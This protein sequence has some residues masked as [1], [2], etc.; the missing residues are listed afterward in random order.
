MT[1]TWLKNSKASGYVVRYIKNGKT[2]TKTYKGKTKTKATLSLKKG[3]YKF[4]VRCY[5]NKSGKYYSVYST[6]KS[7]KVK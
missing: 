1:L 6:A 5:I 7:V 3:S 4:S 2:Y